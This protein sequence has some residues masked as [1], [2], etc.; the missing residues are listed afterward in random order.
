[1]TIIT[2]HPTITYVVSSGGVKGDSKSTVSKVAH[3]QT[4]NVEGAFREP[5]HADEI[6][7]D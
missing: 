5:V 4:Q 3:H 1:M 2:P 6:D 7:A